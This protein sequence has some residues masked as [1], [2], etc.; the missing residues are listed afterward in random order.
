MGKRI[1]IQDIADAL[2]LSRN[3]VSKAL[4]NTGVLADETRQKILHKAEE[5]GYRRF[6]YLPQSSPT[7]ASEIKELALITQNMPYGSHF[8]TYALNTFQEK[9][10]QNN[11]RLS[12]YPVRDTE[13]SSL[14]LPIGFDRDQTAGILC[15]ELFDSSYIA[16]LDQLNLPLLFIDTASDVDLTRTNADFLLMENTLSVYRLT[17]SLI[18]KGCTRLAFAG[19]PNHCRSFLE[20]HQGF[21]SALHANGLTPCNTLFTGKTVFSNADSLG[22]AISQMI[23]LPEA[24]VCANDFVAIDLIRALRKRGFRVPEDVMITGFDNS[25]ESR[26][27]DPHLTTVDIPSSQMGYLA[28]DLLLSRIKEPDTPYRIMHVRTSIKYRASTGRLNLS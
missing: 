16:M 2:G 7:E 22:E 5:L 26:I 11:C 18:Q 15:L 4:N 19:D 12:M 6:V 14:Q 13:I 23:Q 17:D 9:I 10:S 27:I 3:T 28:A 25:A 21:L 1:T 20:R 24:F 8:G